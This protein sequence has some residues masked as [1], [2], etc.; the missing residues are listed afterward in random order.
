MKL[1]LERDTFT[2]KSTT[3]ILYQEFDEGDGNFSYKEICYTL[4]DKCRE[5]FGKPETFVKVYG[6]TAIPYGTYKV[7]MDFSNRFQRIMPHLLDVKFFSGIRIHSGN[8]DLNSSGCVIVAKK[9]AK[10]MVFESK[11]YFLKEFN[12]WLKEVFD[13]GEEIWIE[14]TKAEE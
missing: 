9:R 8:S 5:E 14:I 13:K 7:V 3:G 10:D 11:E 2:D 12:P 1:L 4:E 6:E